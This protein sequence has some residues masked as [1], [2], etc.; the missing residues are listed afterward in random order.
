MLARPGKFEPFFWCVG[1]IAGGAAVLVNHR[2][3]HAN[4]GRLRGHLRCPRHA[5]IHLRCH[6]PQPRFSALALNGGRKGNQATSQR[7]PDQGFVHTSSSL[8]AKEKPRSLT[9]SHRDLRWKGFFAQ[10]REAY[11]SNLPQPVTDAKDLFKSF[12]VVQSARLGYSPAL[13]RGRRAFAACLLRRRASN[14]LHQV[15]GVDLLEKCILDVVRGELHILP[16]R[17]YGL[18]QR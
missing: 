7:R 16:R 11:A 18:I 17:H 8:S 14:Y 12:A 10:V 1:G 5:H 2:L 4:L 13:A 6:L 9:L 3:R 15:A